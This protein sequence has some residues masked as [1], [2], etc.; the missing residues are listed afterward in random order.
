MLKLKLRINGLFSLEKQNLKERR[1]CFH[2]SHFQRKTCTHAIS[3]Y[4]KIKGVDKFLQHICAT[5]WREDNINSLHPKC[6]ENCPFQ[7]N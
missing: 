5:C 7:D 4:G 6:S 3:H 1:I 2:C